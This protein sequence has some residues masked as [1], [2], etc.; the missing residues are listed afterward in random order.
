MSRLSPQAYAEKWG[1][2]MKASISD[3]VS[4]IEKVTE[5]PTAKAAQALDRA[6]IAYQEA[7]SSGRTAAKLN[8]VSL[9][10][11]KEVTKAKV[12]SRLASGV[13]SASAK[14]VQMASRLLPF[15]DAAADAANALPKGTLSDSIN[16]MTRFVTLM[17]EAKG[18]I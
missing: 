9:S 3:V 5:S 15:V 14:Q 16:R 6:A 13:D 1:R 18:K 17:S 7:I 11:W 12:T 4:G 10:E 8:A 2:N